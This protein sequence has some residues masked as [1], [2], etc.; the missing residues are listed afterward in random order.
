[1]GIPCSHALTVIRALNKNVEDFTAFYWLV[2]NQLMAFSF[3]PIEIGTER[4]IRTHMALIRI[5]DL[6]ATIHIEPPPTRAVRGPQV[7]KRKL[8][9]VVLILQGLITIIVQAVGHLI[10][11]RQINIASVIG[12]LHSEEGLMILIFCKLII[13]SVISE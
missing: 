4:T 8:K 12:R 3:D 13:T 10:I 1:M 5:E 11:L 6:Q 7:K 9:D 2:L